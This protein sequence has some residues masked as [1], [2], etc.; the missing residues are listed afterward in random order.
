MKLF[1][2]LREKMRRKEG[3]EEK[4]E[5]VRKKNELSEKIIARY[6]KNHT[7]GH[8]ELRII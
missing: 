3:F 6:G 7:N 8:Q 1:K 5:V 4:R 2:K